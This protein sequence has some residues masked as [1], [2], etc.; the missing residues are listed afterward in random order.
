MKE[1]TLD[2]V[3]TFHFDKYIAIPLSDNWLEANGGK[4]LEFD[5]KLTL[6]GKLILSASLEGLSD[7]IKSVDDNVITNQL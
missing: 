2:K 1:I 3:K 7:R 4:P 6:D 5:A